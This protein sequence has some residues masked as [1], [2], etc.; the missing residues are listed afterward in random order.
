M[1]NDDR[2]GSNNYNNVV[3]FLTMNII[4]KT[5]I[6]K[7]ALVWEKSKN[8]WTIISDIWRPPGHESIRYSWCPLYLSS[9]RKLWV[10]GN[11]YSNSTFLG[12][13]RGPGCGEIIESEQHN[14]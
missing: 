9:L 11:H 5:K 10:C 2:L 7:R 3:E 6:P 8:A 14:F 12:V 13:Q 1:E 4:C